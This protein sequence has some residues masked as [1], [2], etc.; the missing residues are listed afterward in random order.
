MV[1]NFL[2]ELLATS[3]SFVA[4]AVPSCFV[5]VHLNPLTLAI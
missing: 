2:A 3:T 4:D 5:N 1:A